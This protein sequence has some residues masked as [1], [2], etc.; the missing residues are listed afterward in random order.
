MEEEK[1]ENKFTKDEIIEFE[2]LINLSFNDEKRE[3]LQ[4]NL[5]ELYNNIEILRKVELDNAV[6][7][8][9]QF[10][11]YIHTNITKE[12]EVF[13]PTEK[14]DLQRPDNL[15][16]LAYSSIPELAYYIKF[17]IISS[18]EL[19]EMYIN[20]LK[21]Y[22]KILECVITLIEEEALQKAKIA[23]EEIISGA[24]KGILHGIPYGVKDLLAYPNYKTTWGAVPYQDQELD[25]KAEVIKRLEDAGAILVAKLSLG[26]LAWGDV[27]FDGFTKT[28]WNLEEGSSG[29]SAGPASASAAGLVAFSIGSETY[30]SIVSPSTKCGTT[31]LRPSYGRV[32]RYGA[33]ALSW[34]MDKLGP[35]CRSVED[36]AIVFNTIHGLD[37]R[38][39]STVE[40]S[41]SWDVSKNISKLRVG[42][43]KTD[44][45]KEYDFKSY[46]DLVL[47]KFKELSIDLIAVELPDYPVNEMSFILWAE[48]ATAF[49]NLTNSGDDDLLVRQEKLAWP[50]FFRVARFIPAVEYIKANR[51][52][53]SL[54]QAMN[55]LFDEIDVLIAPS[56]S[57]A[58]IMTNLTGHPCVV[59]PTGFR[60]NNVPSSITFISNLL[61]EEELMYV[62]KLYQDN[63]KHHSKTPQDI[64]DKALIQ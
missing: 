2:K 37:K 14:I 11:P 32:S 3:L 43:L 49:E 5:T 56:F 57:N 7:P 12:T 54:I 16:D 21:R 34:S 17:Q 59:L 8:S 25:E 28:P 41:F 22:D 15:E 48:A 36:C 26:A 63:T 50:N 53:T 58:L 60:D 35:I 55:K 6:L 1:K 40:S 52:R 33:M 47:D 29:S 46:D 30:G 44:M 19:T 51:L 23:D 45:E 42:Y 10:N 18:Y 24:Y 61:N 27:W 62:A 13:N 31:G 64:L 9:I 20:R 39:P 4:E 38:D